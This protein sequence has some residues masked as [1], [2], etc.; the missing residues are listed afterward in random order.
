MSLGSRSQIK[1]HTK[2]IEC[3]PNFT[4]LAGGKTSC[5]PRLSVQPENIYHKQVQAQLEKNKSKDSILNFR[6][7]TL[8]RWFPTEKRGISLFLV[9][10]V[11]Q[12]ETMY[13]SYK[14][15]LI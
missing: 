11:T 14:N 13:L 10:R 1:L 5:C 4:A 6:A 8:L 15:V 9:S 3:I 2:L 7:K 12:T